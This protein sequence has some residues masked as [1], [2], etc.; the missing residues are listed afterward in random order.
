MYYE[1]T[2]HKLSY[3]YISHENV[4]YLLEIRAEKIDNK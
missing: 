3:F 2:E 4:I 1:V